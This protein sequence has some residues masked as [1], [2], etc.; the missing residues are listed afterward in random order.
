MRLAEHRP[1]TSG[2]MMRI[3]HPLLLAVAFVL[4]AAPAQ[5]AETRSQQVEVEARFLE[6]NTEFLAD[7]GV[8]FN[9]VE[10]SYSSTGAQAP[11]DSSHTRV[12][13]S[14]GG[15]VNLMGVLFPSGN[16]PFGAGP[17]AVGIGVLAQG[18]Y[19]SDESLI[20]I[21]RHPGVQ[22]PDVIG[23]RD[24]DTAVDLVATTRLPIAIVPKMGGDG[25]I[26]L[27][28]QPLIGAS[29]THVKTSLHSDQTGAG[30]LDL[31]NTDTDMKAG[32]V[33]GIGVTTKIPV[34]S[35]IPVLAGLFYKARRVPRTSVEVNSTF[36]FTEQ[37]KVDDSWQHSVELMIMIPITIVRDP[38]AGD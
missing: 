17:A 28:L 35:K 13:G 14:G 29:F 2:G 36:G 9:P 34:L 15:G 6:V 3:R 21:K 4:L 25:N 19:E 31:R 8:A 16:G 12:S 22:D 30:G 27:S 5:A 23:R 18:F 24:I 38:F 1:Y 33:T 32:V 10:A 20:K 7:L 11:A 26:V 37:L